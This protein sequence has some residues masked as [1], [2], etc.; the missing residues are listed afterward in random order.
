M[1]SANPVQ[2]G[3]TM[4]TMFKWATLAVA[5]LALNACQRDAERAPDDAAAADASANA[6]AQSEAEEMVNPVTSPTPK[7]GTA[8]KGE[9][10]KAATKQ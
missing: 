9:T 2:W 5:A 4:R 10:E 6:E 1:P 7:A 3:K 8:K